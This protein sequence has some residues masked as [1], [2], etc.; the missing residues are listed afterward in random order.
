M[1]FSRVG[2]F[3]SV[4]ALCAA[5]QALARDEPLWELGVG[6]A[7]ATFPA[8]RGSQRQRS[9]VLP[10]PY[11]V[12]RGDRLRVGRDG[13]RGLL[14]QT[15]EYE[16]DFSVDGAIPVDSTDEGPRA[17][18]EE[19]D[20]VVEMGPS[21]VIKLEQTATGR[22]SFR[23]PLRAAVA[24]GNDPL[25]TSQVGWTLHPSLD[26]DAPKLVGDWDFRFNAGP[27]FASR[28]YHA[29]YY[30][31]ASE[32]ATPE[33]P[34]YRAAAGYSGLAFHVSAARRFERFWVGAFLR[35]DNLA[36]T[37]FEDSPLVE[38]THAVSGGI[39]ISWIFGESA[40]RVEV[41]D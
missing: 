22:W 17:G 11:V 21:L 14:A 41:E 28:A 39:G 35:Y 12:Y 25:S 26:L 8:Y 13:A 23:L 15:P 31:V 27:R 29:Y 32:Y 6:V 4:L 5:Q 24:V 40:R 38:T 19:L 7:G 37:A 1:H 33:R 36:G 10:I 30:E 20:P 3:L 2:V 16:V 18:M 34:A 9:F